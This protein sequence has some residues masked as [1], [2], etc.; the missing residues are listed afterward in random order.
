MS[1]AAHGMSLVILDRGAVFDG[2]G[3]SKL[4]I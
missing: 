1:F 3:R 4:L 2:V